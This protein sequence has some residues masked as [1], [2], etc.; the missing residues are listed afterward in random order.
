MAQQEQWERALEMAR[1]VLDELETK[2]AGYTALTVPPSLVIERQEKLKEIAR[3]E[4]LLA[5]KEGDA[6]PNTL[7]RR[8]PFFGRKKE[9]SRALDAL[10]PDDRGWGL[11]ID[12]IGG[13]G[14]TALAVEVA[15]LCYEQARFDAALFTSAKLTRLVPD[16]E[17]PIT[18]TA[19]TLDAMLSEIARALGRQAVAQLA[20]A[21]KRRGLL[22]ELRRYSGP[23]RRVLLIL[24][25]LE[26]IPAEEQMGLFE[27]L[28]HL[29]QDCKAI[30]TSR[31]RAGEGAVWLR[32]EKIAWESAQEIIADQ[33]RRAPRL[34]RI[35]AQAGEARWQ[36]IYDATGGSPLALNWTLGLMRVR[37]LSLD[38]ALD[39][40]RRG[41]AGDSPLH[42]FMYREARS[43]MGVDDWRVLGALSL[44]ATPARFAALTSVTGLTRLALESTLERLDAYA[45]VNTEGPDGPYSL[46]PLTRQL[47]SGELAAQPETAQ[48]LQSRFTRYWVDFAEQYGGEDKDAYQTYDRLGAEWPN[49]EATATLLHDRAGET[50]PLQDEEAARMLNDLADTLRIFLWFRG[51]WE[52]RVRLNEW[53]YR[54]MAALEDWRNAGWHAYD[55]AWFRY[56]RAE[57]DRAAAWAD[58]MAEAMEQGGTR[59]DQTYAT[60]MR[61]R[62]ARQRGNIDDA[63]RLLI[64]TLAA[65]RDM[66][67]ETDQAIVLNDLGELTGERQDY[68]RAEKYYREA[69]K[70]HEK[71]SETAYQP[72][73][74]GNL[75]ELALD[76]GRPDEAREWFERALSLAQEVERQDTVAQAQ[77]GLARVLEEEGRPAEA[78]PLA[79]AALQIYERLR[80][81]DLEKMRQLVARLRGK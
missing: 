10:S 24:D 60:H 41:A 69:L 51:Y 27:F 70:I 11:M 67:E 64:E 36:E 73:I 61:G 72:D 25:N 15:Y 22:D 26:T 3:L 48:V 39:V 57:T 6:L 16:G 80:D 53:A 55:V 19:V 71:H 62:V 4:S 29:P 74:C 76:Q 81:K 13:I 79:E 45:L 44:F 63:E 68:D 5:G 2:I 14:K 59:R 8:R 40:L 32:L 12:G 20:G 75:G 58:R 66:G 9:I 17:R 52:E 7:P 54:A 56:Y 28:R 33:A 31:R 37:N 78:L 18:D 47:A 50:A 42:E 34:E 43:E 49:L 21:E 23:E 65:H 1:R 77:S 30:V 35:L 46:H 38:R